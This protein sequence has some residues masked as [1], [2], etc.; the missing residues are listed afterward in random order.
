MGEKHIL[1]KNTVACYLRYMCFK[2]LIKGGELNSWGGSLL[3]GGSERAIL[4]AHQ[5]RICCNAGASGNLGSIPGSGRS[6]GE[7]RIGNPLQYSCLKNPMDREAWQ[8]TVH[9]VTRNQTRLKQPGTHTHV[10]LITSV[11]KCS[12]LFTFLEIFEKYC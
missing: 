11:W 2:K 8:A 7:G 1:Q 3:D 12:L 9:R 6:P 10:T 4:V 5:Q